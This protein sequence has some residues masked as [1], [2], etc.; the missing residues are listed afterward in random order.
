[1]AS[2]HKWDVKNGFFSLISD[3]LAL[4][5]VEGP[6]LGC[7]FTWMYFIS[8]FL[9]QVVKWGNEPETPKSEMLDFNI[10]YKLSCH[11][12]QYRGYLYWLR[13]DQFY[14][15]LLT[16]PRFLSFSFFLAKSIYYPIIISCGAACWGEANRAI[17][18]H[19]SSETSESAKDFLDI[20]DH[21]NLALPNHAVSNNRSAIG[22]KTG[23]TAISPWFCKIEYGGGSGAMP[24]CLLVKACPGAHAAL[25]MPLNK[26]NLFTGHFWKKLTYGFSDVVKNWSLF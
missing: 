23:K 22:R 5:G 2:Y 24:R 8:T 13:V 9:L 17:N 7:R 14:S 25:V 12:L 26:I 20:F 19:F 6:C 21:L 15:R 16:W 4:G 3:G 11:F 18:Y 1:M 10:F